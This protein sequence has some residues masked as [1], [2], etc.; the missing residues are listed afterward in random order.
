LHLQVKVP[1]SAGVQ[2][3]VLFT[4]EQ[5]VP[6]VCSQSGPDPGHAGQDDVTTPLHVT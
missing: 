5:E 4:G 6:F 3:I 2:L 1:P